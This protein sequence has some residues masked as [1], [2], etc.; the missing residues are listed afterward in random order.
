MQYPTGSIVFNTAREVSSQTG[1]MSQYHYRQALA[2]II[3][4]LE[5]IEGLISKQKTSRSQDYRNQV[6]AHIL[7]I[8]QWNEFW[9][10]D[11]KAQSF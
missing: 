10:I 2:Y 6:Y 9:G 4:Q 5:E 1:R 8:I 7:N 11:K 3:D